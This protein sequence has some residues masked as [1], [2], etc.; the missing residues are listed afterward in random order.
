MTDKEKPLTKKQLKSLKKQMLYYILV[1]SE[2]KNG[3][4]YNRYKNHK[5]KDQIICLKQLSQ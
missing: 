2:Y 1:G 5:R 3:V 4:Y